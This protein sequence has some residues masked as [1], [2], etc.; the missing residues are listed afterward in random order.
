M[1]ALGDKIASTIV[2]QSALV[3]CISWSGD[4]IVVNTKD[5]NGYI[6]VNPDIY[7]N[8]TTHNANQGLLHAKRIG[9]PVMVKASEGGGGKGIRLV[10]FESEF[11]NSFHQVQKE[12]PG[13]PIFIMKMAAN[14]RHL[15]I[16]LLADSY[17]NAI[18][19]FGRDCSVQRRH[20]KILEEAPI[21]IADE[22]VITL[23]A[24]S[25]VRLACLVGY[26]SAGMVVISKNII[27]VNRDC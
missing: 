4:G 7:S 6:C 12:V 18:A 24:A 9:F 10:K 15:E 5:K 22:D 11:K 19:L 3:P 23:M 17:G 21:T 14:A 16:Q 8:A 27:T 25:A 2:A 26:V 13:S 1:R 20:Q